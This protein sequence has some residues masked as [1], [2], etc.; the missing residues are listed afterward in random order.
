MSKYNL[1]SAKYSDC[2]KCY[3]LSTEIG[4]AGSPGGESVVSSLE[5]GLPALCLEKAHWICVLSGGVQSRE[6]GG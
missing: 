3:L 4:R 2:T 6:C 5:G 1:D